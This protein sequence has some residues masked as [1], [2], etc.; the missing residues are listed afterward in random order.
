ME[1]KAFWLIASCMIAATLVSFTA[2]TAQ[3]RNGQQSNQAARKLKLVKYGKAEEPR[4]E[5]NSPTC[6]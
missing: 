2:V 6:A 4:R 5:C 3:R 1:R